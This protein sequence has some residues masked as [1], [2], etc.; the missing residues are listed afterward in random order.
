MDEVNVYD[1]EW[2][3]GTEEPGFRNRE[4]PLGETLGAA[5]ARRHDLPDR[6]GTAHLPLP[7]A[8]RRGGVAAR[9]RRDG[10]APDAGR[11]AG[12]RPRRRRR[13]PDRPRRRARRS[14]QR[15]GGGARPDAVDPVRPRDLRLPGQRED[16]AP[17][18]DSCAR[19][20]PARACSTARRRTSST[21]TG[22]AASDPLGDV[23]LLRHADRLERRDRR[24]SRSSSSAP[25]ARRI[26]SRATTASSRRSR[27]RRIAATRRCSR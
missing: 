5:E 24:H 6:A 22:S 20:A 11:R 9:A 15:R 25:S 16:R 12:A 19:T 27:P 23:R 3:D 17:P 18:P 10:D 14:L 21:S 7:L 26:C 4:R 13:V 1:D 2:T 8:L